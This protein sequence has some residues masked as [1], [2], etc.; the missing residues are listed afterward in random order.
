[1]MLLEIIDENVLTKLW[2]YQIIW[3]LFAG[4]NTIILCSVH[5]IWFVKYLFSAKIWFVKSSTRIMKCKSQVIKLNPVSLTLTWWV[6]G[7]GQ[8]GEEGL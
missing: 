1:M 4:F 8:W 7:G 5:S 3:Y 2:Y 6:G